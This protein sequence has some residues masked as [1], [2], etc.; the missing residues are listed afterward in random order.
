M[1]ELA[2]IALDEHAENPRQNPLQPSYR[3][4]LSAQFM[5]PPSGM[6]PLYLP[7]STVFAA[8][9]FV[10]MTSCGYEKNQQK[11]PPTPPAT[12][13][14]SGPSLLSSIPR[15]DAKNFLVTKYAPN[16]PA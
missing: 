4:I 16:Y 2:I 13:W 15:M 14:S 12:N 11:K 1:K 5:M 8:Y 6:N 3:Y 7:N 9:S 10:F